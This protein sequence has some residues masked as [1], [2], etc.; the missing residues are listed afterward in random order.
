MFKGLKEPS[1]TEKILPKAAVTAAVLMVGL[2][3]L[4]FEVPCP[5]AR[6]G[7]PVWG[8]G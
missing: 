6:A 8:A 7:V 1:L 3:A 4:F 5:F 2:Y